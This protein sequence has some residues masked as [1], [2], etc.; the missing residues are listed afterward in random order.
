MGRQTSF[1]DL[2]SKQCS[3]ASFSLKKQTI[4]HPHSKRRGCYC[5]NTR[6]MGVTRTN[7]VVFIWIGAQP[8][9]VRTPK[10]VGVLSPAWHKNN[11][12]YDGMTLVFFLPTRTPG[13]TWTWTSSISRRSQVIAKKNSRFG[14][15][16]THRFLRSR[17]IASHV[18]DDLCSI[19]VRPSIFCFGAVKTNAFQNPHGARA[20]FFLHAFSMK[21][22]KPRIAFRKSFSWSLKAMKHQI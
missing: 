21:K 4:L 3:T 15:W 6:R 5:V 20:I 9:K 11:H 8:N 13:Y 19:A 10:L 18:D 22:H 2:H 14:T 12:R 17:P 16:T 7:N 1:L